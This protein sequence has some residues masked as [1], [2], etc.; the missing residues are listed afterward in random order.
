M[1][2]LHSNVSPSVTTDL[3]RVFR[4][5]HWLAHGRYWTPKIGRECD[6][7]DIYALAESVY[8]G[9]PFEV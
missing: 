5:R 9:F 3:E 7:D 8:N 2:Q 4:Y 1:W 6:Y